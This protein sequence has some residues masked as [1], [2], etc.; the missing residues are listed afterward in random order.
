MIIFDSSTLILLARTDLLERF[1]I[2]L[3][4][5]IVIPRAV[6][7]ES[8]EEKDSVDAIVIQRAIRE[9]RIRVKT[10]KET[11]LS[12]NIS[13]DFGLGQGETEAIALASSQQAQVL[14]TDDK[15]AILACRLLKIPYTTAIDILIRMYQKEL[16]DKNEAQLKLNVLE[17]YGRYKREIIL[18]AKS[19]LGV[20]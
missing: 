8:C 2:N 7:K 18:D 17:R 20:G 5:P 10:L 16:L 14:A 1:M 11:K 12:Q 9:K 4:D 6:E 13:K 15:R 3:N 19:R